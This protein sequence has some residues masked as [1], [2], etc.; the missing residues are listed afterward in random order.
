MGPGLK[1]ILQ[2]HSKL[3]K[4]IIKPLNTDPDT[5]NISHL[6]SSHGQQKY[7]DRIHVLEFE[8]RSSTVDPNWVACA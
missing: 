8:Y 6:P 7:T 3:P 5:S 2:Y 1:Y 4:N